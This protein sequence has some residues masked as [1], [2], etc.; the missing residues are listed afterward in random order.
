MKTA[1]L[2]NLGCKVNSYETDAMQQLLEE[3]GYQIVPFH[4]RADVYVINTCSVTNVA[5]HKSRQMIHR[6]KKQNPEAAVVAAG[7]YV[8]TSPGQMREDLAVDIILG[9]NRKNDLIRLLDEY[10]SEHSRRE[11]TEAGEMALEDLVDINSGLQP[12][13]DLKVSGPKEHTRA[14]VK[15]QDGCNQFCSYCIIP[16]A[17]GRIR[18]RSVESVIA[19]VQ[20]LAE[21][22]IQEVVLTGI[23]I[24]SYGKDSSDTLLHLIQEVHG[25]A[26]IRRI[27]LGSLEPR[28][29]TEEFARSLAALPK[30]CPHF[31]LSLQSGSAGVLQRMNRHYTPEEFLDKCRILRSVY[32]HPGITTDI[33]VGFP[34]ETEEEFRETCAF[35]RQAQFYEVH[36]FKYSRRDGTKAAAM[37]GQIPEQ[38]KTRR[39]HI[40]MGLAEELKRDYLARYEGKTVEVLFEH[41]TE[42]GGVRGFEGFTREYVKVFLPESGRDLH[43]CIETVE[44][45]QCLY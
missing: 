40:L 24:S 7:C 10:F 15:I 31:H 2:H 6:A 22:G 17:R 28:L 44:F 8:Q 11:E 34:Q 27:R 30:V 42:R 35:A 43:N 12:Y 39:S 33:I 38:E 41:Q 3:A 19:E 13:E 1:A 23:H 36:V 45:S 16:Y 5:D 29:I 32:D 21:Q 18:S 4:E 14:F 26:G 37:S 20:G 25:I 9:N